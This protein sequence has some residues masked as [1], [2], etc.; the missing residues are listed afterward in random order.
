MK[1]YGNKKKSVKTS[2]T[3]ELPDYSNKE[4]RLKKERASGGM[5]QTYS[6]ANKSHL[7]DC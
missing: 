7:G 1:K 3:M 5:S 2:G 4:A 6:S